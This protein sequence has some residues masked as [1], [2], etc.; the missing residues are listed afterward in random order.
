MILPMQLVML[1]RL[2]LPPLVE[3]LRLSARLWATL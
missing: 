2:L 3:T 1:L